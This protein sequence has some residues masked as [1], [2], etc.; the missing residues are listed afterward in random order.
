VNDDI[1]EVRA[2]DQATL[3]GLQAWGWV[4]YIL[5]LLVAIGAVIPGAQ[6]SVL[7]LVVALVIDL[8]KRSDAR[9]TWHESHFSWR[10]RSVI[11]AGVLYVVTFPFFL[12]GL[13]LFNPA[14]VLISIWFLYRIVRGM[15]AMNKYE[16]LPQ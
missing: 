15:I 9:G 14:W 13:F 2:V 4:S 1:V 5:H 12:L 6:I 10:L 11:W 7:V 16:P 3:D 8:V